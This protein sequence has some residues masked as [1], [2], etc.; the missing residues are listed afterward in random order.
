MKI[1][2][3]LA[4]LSLTACSTPP[5]LLAAMYDSNDPCQN[6]YKDPNYQMPSFCGA[7]SGTRYVTRDYRSGN[8]LTVTKAQK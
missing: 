8:Y 7:G 1:I 6:Y 2:L 4:C 5:R 3:I